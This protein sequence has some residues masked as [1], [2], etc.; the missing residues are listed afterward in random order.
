M[1]NVNYGSGVT[2]AGRAIAA[3]EIFSN[4]SSS[5]APL[6]YLLHTH[7]QNAFIWQILHDG[8]S[9]RSLLFYCIL[10]P[11]LGEGGNLWPVSGGNFLDRFLQ[12]L[13]NRF[14]PGE[15]ELKITA[16]TET[17][18]LGWFS[19]RQGLT[20][21]AFKP[22]KM[23]ETQPRSGHC[24]PHYIHSYILKPFVYSYLF[25]VVFVIATFS[26]YSMVCQK[27]FL[28]TFHMGLVYKWVKRFYIFVTLYECS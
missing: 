25:S 27:I 14:R 13:L 24:S 12:C 8:D 1:V 6:L 5:P 11:P 10:F 2:A 15:Q 3:V 19:T 21:L 20:E 17:V 7:W 26:A 28:K 9:P 23:A 16:L 22:F 18:S 4:K